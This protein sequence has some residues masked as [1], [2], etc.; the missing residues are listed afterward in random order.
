MQ[1]RKSLSWRA[2]KGINEQSNSAYHMMPIKLLSAKS[3]VVAGVKYELEILVGQ[4]ECLKNQ[5]SS[6]DV[7][8]ETCKEKPG[9]NRQVYVVSV[10]Q[11]PWEDFEQF[12]IKEARE[13]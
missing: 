7:K 5:L 9:G 10:W 3:Q 11:K 4:T 1:N 8:P 12:T 2:M 13:A 6:E